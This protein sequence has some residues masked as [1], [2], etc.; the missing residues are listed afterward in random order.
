MRTGGQR[1]S[2]LVWVLEGGTVVLHHLQSSITICPFDVF[3]SSF[4]QLTKRRTLVLCLFFLKL[5][6]AGFFVVVG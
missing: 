6:V 5:F 1:I 3:G 2:E 4:T